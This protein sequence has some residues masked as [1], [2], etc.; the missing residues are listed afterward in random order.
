MAALAL[1][2]NVTAPLT[3][4]LRPG[5]SCRSKYGESTD[6]APAKAQAAMRRQRTK[7]R[8]SQATVAPRSAAISAAPSIRPASRGGAVAIASPGGR[9]TGPFEKTA[10]GLQCPARREGESE[11][12]KPARPLGRGHQKNLRQSGFP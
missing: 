11:N 12:L 2:P 10:E 4:R 9:A 3:S 7:A 1:K 5:S 6:T 8:G